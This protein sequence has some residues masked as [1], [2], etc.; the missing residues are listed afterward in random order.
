MTQK[1]TSATDAST[2]I[3]V[4]LVTLDN[5]VNGAIVR[6]EKRLVHDLP[7]IHFRSFAATEWEGDE[8]SLIECREAIAEGDII[9]VTMLFME[10]HINAVSDAL[11]ARRD[12]C[13]ALICCMSAPEVMQYTRM[14]RFT[15]DSEP[16][17]PIALLKR[18]RGTPKDGKPAATGERQLAM[19]RRLPRI[20]RFIPGTAQD[21]RTYF[22]TLQYWLA[23]SEDNLA[24]MVNLLVHRYAAGPRAV[25]RQIAREQPPIEYPDVGIYQMEG[26]QRIV[27]SADG[28][29]EPE[30][31]SGTVGLLL[32]RSYALAGN[33]RHYDAVIQALE[34]RGIKVIPAFAAGLDAR[35]AVKRFFMQEGESVVDAV[36]SLTGFSLVGGP[37]YN[38][39][40]AAQEMLSE[41]N[42]PYLAVQAL[43]FQS[44]NQWRDSPMGLMPVEA[45]MMV[46]IPELDGATGP[47]VFSGRNR[48]DPKRSFDMSP[49]MERID[50]LADRIRKLVTLR[51]MPRSDRKIGITIFNF[52]PNSGAMGSAA[53]L[54][55]F[56]SVLNT[57]TALKKAG[58]VVDVPPSVEALRE[59][60][61]VGNSERYGAEANVHATISVDDHVAREPYLEEIEAQWGPAPGKHWTDGRQLFVLGKT[62]GNVFIGVQPAMGYEGDPMRLLFEGGLAPTHIFSA[63]YRWLRE[64][65]AAD[66]VLHF[67][68]HGALEFMPGKQVGLSD[69]CWP[70]RL[71]ADLPNFYLYAANN[72]SEG[73]IAKRRSAATLISYLTP[74]VTRAD[75]HKQFAELR[76]MI[77]RWRTRDPRAHD[78]QLMPLLEA[79]SAQAE[80]CEL[81]HSTTPERIV[82]A[83][84]WVGEL[85]TQLDEIETALIPFGMHVVGAPM[86]SDE[87]AETMSAIA[88]AGGAKEVDPLRLDRLLASH[89][90][91]AL[92]TML[93]ESAVA[94]DKAPE[95]AD[96]LCDAFE[97][98]AKE[99]ELPALIDA[100]DANFI[101]PVSGGDLIR[102][103]ESLP[104]GRNLHGFDPFR[105][106]SAFAVIEGERQAKQ[107]IARHVADS[108]LLPTSVALV[109]WGTDNLKSEGVAIGQALSLIGARPRFDSYGR[110][111]GAELISLSELGRARIDVLMTLSGIFRDLLPMQTRLLAEAAFL[112]ADA[113][114]P[115]ELNPIR[116]SALA[117]QEKHECDLDTAA[118]RVFSNSEGAYGSNVNMLVDSGRWDDESE[119]ADTYTNRKG[120]AYGRAGAVSQQTE[121]LN[122]VLGNVDLAYQ[123]LDSVELG[124]TTVDHYFDTLG[125]ISSA[126]Q[127]A[128]GDSVPVYIADHTGSGDGKVRTLDEQVALEARTRLLNPKWYESMLD[129]GYEGVRQIEAHLTNTMGWSATAGGV[130][131]WVY[132]QASETFILDEDMRRRLAELNP[133]AAS[134]VANRL[135]E[136]QERDYWGA[137]EEQLEALRRAGED[138]EDLL[139]GITGEVAA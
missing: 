72:P 9:I 126:V 123:N 64:D 137:D 129:H 30:E 71:I 95:L 111:C 125:G 90:K 42:V 121:L 43:E 52:P 78:T 127:R 57:L 38:D 56:R 76:S 68:T 48:D 119:F 114:E 80:R 87:R 133:V 128:K 50:R 34:S 139:E 104:T 53:H 49:E 40:D 93:T 73:L 11:A 108:G 74:P 36:V 91:G 46:A 12:H 84:P 18:L 29:A 32:M 120:F 103:P 3:N 112:A 35:P 24:R 22:L 105:L 45:T 130:A 37:A 39:T 106:P 60:L 14:G 23:G 41:L 79:I 118:L 110:L 62:F 102:N 1:H 101:P 85:R 6:A 7:G 107:L 116:R 92:Q 63:Y 4:V 98:L 138:L 20:L 58:Y 17:G 33:T 27:D 26:R 21:V 5:H 99:C 115:L 83:E 28:I 31:H 44:I 51:R 16:S 15:M 8:K 19:L 135:I 2:P 117:Y 86:S 61:L 82:D 81:S 122:E 132:K 70:D 97:N 113:D 88:E 59:A 13:D 67:G 134:R 54:N 65:Y 47:M 89:D 109:L 100:L 55:V 94:A 124:I 25:L 69:K 10:P 66:A 75:L 96:R 77:D 131:P 136:A